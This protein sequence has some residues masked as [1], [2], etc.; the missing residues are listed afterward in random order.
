MRGKNKGAKARKARELERK[1]RR[2]QTLSAKVKNC[3]LP[4]IRF[5]DRGASSPERTPHAH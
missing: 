5:I 2:C 1:R 3:P 4:P